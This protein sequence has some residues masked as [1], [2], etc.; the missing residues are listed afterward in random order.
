[1]RIW[2]AVVLVLIPLTNS[3]TGELWSGKK[4]G[5]AYQAPVG[6]F[7]TAG[8]HTFEDHFH[9]KLKLPMPEDKFLSLIEKLHLDYDGYGPD[10][11]GISHS[12]HRNIVYGAPMVVPNYD[13][14]TTSHFYTIRGADYD[15]HGG[16]WEFGMNAE[17]DEYT[18]LV[19]HHHVVVYFENDCALS[20]GL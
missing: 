6:V 4:P 14:T 15:H 11:D 19:N 3:A 18:V 17:H 8:C 13:M 7:S 2:L 1:M 10:A 9:I 16:W 5:V 12:T 20:G